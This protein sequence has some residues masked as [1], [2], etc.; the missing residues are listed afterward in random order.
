MNKRILILCA[1]ILISI[2][3][4]GC[5][6]ENKRSGENELSSSCE[7]PPQSFMWNNT[8]YKLEKIGDRELEPG[9]K[10]GY[11]S[12]DN[13]KFTVQAEGPNA[14]YNLYTYGSPLESNRLLYFGEWGRA[15][16]TPIDEKQ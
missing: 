9:M 7:A 14:T 2:I 16:Y 13:G 12:C 4:S 6:S 5:Y 1:L 11:L 8:T 3:F 10:Y 15:L